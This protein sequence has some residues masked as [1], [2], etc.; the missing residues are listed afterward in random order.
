MKGTHVVFIG[1]IIIYTFYLRPP[2]LCLLSCLVA[3]HH[4]NGA[5]MQ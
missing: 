5:K 4:H 1:P 3:Q 2:P